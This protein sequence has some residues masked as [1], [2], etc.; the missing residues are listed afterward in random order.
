MAQYE[1]KKE[2]LFLSNGE[3]RYEYG[4]KVVWSIQLTELRLLGEW[5]TDNGP[6]CEDYFI[7]FISGRPPLWNEA[8][9]A[10]NPRIM[11]QLEKEI[12]QPLY[13]GLAA[14]TTFKSRVVWPP[15]LQGHDLFKYSPAPR[16]RGLLNRFKDVIL[17]LIHSELTQEVLEY[18]NDTPAK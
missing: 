11:E 7:G 5:T 10:A 3:L 4:G 16:P 14:S 9:V 13:L 2:T 15:A 1:N 8:P 6:H 12:G 18:F 17:P